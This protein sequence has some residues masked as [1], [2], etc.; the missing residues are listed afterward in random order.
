MFLGGPKKIKK[1]LDITYRNLYNT[2]LGEFA[3]N[4]ICP[5]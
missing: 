1:K 2:Y 4:R 3:F 5:A